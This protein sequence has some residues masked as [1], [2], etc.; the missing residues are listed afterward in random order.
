M[1]SFFLLL[2][3][4]CFIFS[5]ARAEG[6]GSPQR[7]NTADQL[8]VKN[9][10]NDT[11]LVAVPEPSPKSLAHYRS[12]LALL[13]VIL[14]WNLVFPAV[15]L[16][17]GFSA[18]M[19]SSAARLG[20][21]WYF[22][23]ALYC[24]AYIAIYYLVSLPLYYYAG[25]IHPH[26]YDLSNQT[27]GKWFSD[28]F[29]GAVVILVLALAVG[30]VPFLLIKKSP[31]R[32]WLYLGLLMAPYLCFMALIQPVWI[33]PLFNKFQPL[34]DKVL[35][36]KILAQ[37]ERVGIEGSRV[38]EVNMS[39]DTK[40]L[41]AYVT[42]FMGTK[43]IVVWDNTLKK[44]NDDELLFV[45]GHEMGHY[46]L[47]HVMKSL[48]FELVLIFI[49]LYIIYLI[50]GRIITRFKVRF[51][52]DNLS[53]FAAMPLGILFTII[54]SLAVMPIDMAHS[55]HF[56]HEADRFGLEL[57]RNNHAA[58]TA[59]VKLQQAAL[60]NPRPGIIYQLWLG[61]HPTLAERIEFCNQYR[62]WE[63]GQP[64]KYSGL[65]NPGL[66]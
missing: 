8:A 13:G 7:T 45:L 43:R 19:R 20:R 24:V 26:N 29:T 62:P 22:T 38:Y 42:G 2:A 5:A 35:E 48:A 63:T 54:L 39:V 49:S 50:A 23:Y 51:G 33:D 59:F 1:K 57:T 21:K 10:T 53:D 31:R 6:L 16:F 64:G 28:Y 41:N 55:R 11:S 46:V 66:Q 32:W 14:L 34:Q 40:T 37:A 12:S 58:A 60:G 15:I 17:T 4:A 30:W 47:N 3:L 65:I 25:F 36:S 9:G 44:M 52:F 18:W 61:S 27:V 56:E